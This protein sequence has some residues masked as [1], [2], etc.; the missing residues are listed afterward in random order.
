MPSTW[1][2]VWKSLYLRRSRSVTY[3]SVLRGFVV[4]MWPVME[5]LPTEIVQTCKSCKST[6]SLPHTSIMSSLSYSMLMFLGLP[7]IITVIMF[8]MIGIVVKKTMMEN[9]YVHSGS[10]YQN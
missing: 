3:D 5:T 1:I 7:S 4:V 10:A 8:L 9:K 6:M 2:V